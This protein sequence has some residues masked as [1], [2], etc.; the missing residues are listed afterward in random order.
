M[1]L[2]CWRSVIAFGSAAE[3]QQGL[4]RDI[5]R[6]RL[7]RIGEHA[8]ASRVERVLALLQGLEPIADTVQITRDQRR[9]VDP[10]GTAR[11]LRIQE[12]AR[13]QH[14][15]REGVARRHRFVGV[16]AVRDESRVLLHEQELLAETAELDQLRFARLVAVESEIVGTERARQRRDHQHRHVERMHADDHACLGGIGLHVEEARLRR[17]LGGRFAFRPGRRG[18]QQKQ[19]SNP[20]AHVHRR[21]PIPEDRDYDPGAR[22]GTRQSRRAHGLRHQPSASLSRICASTA[23]SAVM[24]TTRRTVLAG[25]S[26]CTG[27]ETPI[28]IGPMA[29]PSVIC[30]VML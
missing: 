12:I 26:T 18:G 8:T 15:F 10:P 9:Q 11:R 30:R 20:V 28:R 3:G 19:G 2:S 13:P 17:R 23:A 7:R 5:V 27:F 29:T 6:I 4:E 16:A 22:P 21:P 14:R 25:V 1:K 24:L